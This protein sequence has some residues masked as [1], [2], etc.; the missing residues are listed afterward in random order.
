[1]A[2]NEDG[3]ERTESATPKRLEEARRRG[4]IPRSRDLSTAAVMMT[5]GAGLYFLGGQ[6]AGALHGLMQRGLDVDARAIARSDSNRADTVG[7]GGSMRCSHVC[8]CSA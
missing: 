7:D 5:A 3:Q 8:R 4:Q 6:L 2:E 1:M